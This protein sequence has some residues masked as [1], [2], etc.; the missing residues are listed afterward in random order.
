MSTLTGSATEPTSSLTVPTVGGDTDTWGAILNGTSLQALL[1]YILWLYARATDEEVNTSGAQEGDVLTLTSGMWVPSAPA[2][3]GSGD[4]TGPASSTAG[5]FPDFGDA[6]GKVLGDSGVGPG[7]FATAAQGALAGSAVQPGDDA[8]N[9]G[10][11]AATDGHVLTSDGAGGA[12]W[13]AVPGGASDFLDLTDTPG[14]YAGQGGKLVAVNAGATALEFVT[15]GGGGGIAPLDGVVIVKHGATAG[16]ARPTAAIAYWLGSV[17]PTN[18]QLGD[19]W[20]ETGV[21][22]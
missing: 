21:F 14:S 13:E 19:F 5:N 11:A 17:A 22:D 15:S 6:T 12:A 8:A 18:R 10:S 4:V 9:L 7:D 3:G 1:D 2:A 16:T 20:L